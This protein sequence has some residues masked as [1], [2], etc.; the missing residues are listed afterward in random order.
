MTIFKAKN[1]ADKIEIHR[2]LEKVPNRKNILVRSLGKCTNFRSNSPMWMACVNMAQCTGIYCYLY[3]LPLCCRLESVQYISESFKLYK[4]AR[5]TDCVIDPT[6]KDSEYCMF[7][8]KLI[9]SPHDLNGS[10]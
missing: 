7:I 9:L 3:G 2:K 1:F 5:Y 10:K 6:K 4:K 8:V